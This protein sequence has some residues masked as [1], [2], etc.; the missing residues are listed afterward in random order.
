MIYTVTFN[1]ALDYVLNVEKLNSNDI[2]RSNNEE[3]YA[4]GKGINVST[5]LSRLEI[6]NKALGFLAGFS[7]EYLEKILKK[8]KIK[9][10]FVYL[11]SG[12]TRINVKIKADSELDINASGPE[13]TD[14]DINKLFEKLDEIKTDDY[15]ILAGSVPASLPNNMYEII[16]KRLSDRKINFVVD[17]AGDLLKSI[18]KYKPFLIKPNHHELGGLFSKEIKNESDAVHYAKEL[19]KMGAENVLVSMAENGAL[20][21]DENG[22]ATAVSNAEGNLVSSVGCGDSMV[23]GFIAGYI[24][25]NN[26][27]AALKLGAVC[28]NATA[29]SSSLASKEDIENMR[30]NKHIRIKKIG[31]AI[32]D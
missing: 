10:D 8:E 12:N 29:F 13:I 16:I 6:E 1:P 11:N 4:G 17:A 24:N 23:A 18:L 7:G 30:Q 20:L 9:T 14:D 21:V 26:Y 5:I 27:E 25:S 28:G 31:K 19:Q 3:L 15:L 32:K 22:G 2:N